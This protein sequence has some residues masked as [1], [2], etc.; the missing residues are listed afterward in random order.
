M[1]S[2][3]RQKQL[4]MDRSLYALHGLSLPRATIKALQKRGI[5]CTPGVSVEHQ[6]L[7]K[8]Y[9]LRGV[10]SGGAVVDMGRACAFLAPDG[11]PLPW[12]Q[13][14][15]SL[16][17]NGRHAIYLADSFIRVEMLRVIRTY[18]LAITLHT[19]SLSPERTR[20][21]I[22]SKTI[23]RGRDGAAA[24]DLWKEENRALRGEIAPDFRSRGGEKTALPMHLELAVRGITAAVCCI[25]CRHTHVGVPP[26]MH[27]N[28]SPEEQQAVRRTAYKPQLHT[29][30]RTPGG[31]MSQHHFNATIADG[32]KVT[33]TMGY[34]RPLDYV[35]CTVMDKDGE[36]VYSNLHDD[37]VGLNLQDVNYFRPIL[38]ELGLRVPESMFAEV[39]FDQEHSV[40]NR[41]VIHEQDE[42]PTR[43]E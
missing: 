6:H 30:K 24:R 14:I 19:L 27:D 40:G 36:I 11:Q 10:E 37:A 2:K 43:T 25:G 42:S 39:S 22:S 26:A 5:Y 15:D 12:L 32:R 20:P 1:A 17:V 8:R 29:R 23:F 34:D 4:Q 38:E 31:C 16:A 41:V 3:S 7:A 33:V 21:A 13:S 35:F 28:Q 9:V 18:E